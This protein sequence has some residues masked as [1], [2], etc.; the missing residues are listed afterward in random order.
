MRRHLLEV[1]EVAERIRRGETLLLAG[2]ESALRQLPRGKWIAGTIPYFMTTE[3]GMVDR[4][5]IFVEKLP[6]GFE[7]AGIR[8]YDEDGIA[9]VYVDLPPDGLGVLIAPNGS[10]V[11][12]SFAVNAPRYDR[13]A[14]RPLYGWI[15]GVHL[16][17]LGKAV[18][19]VLDGTTG[20]ALAQHAVVMHV[21]VPPGKVVELGIL[22]PF[23][24]GSGPA[25]TFPST[26]F[27][28][29][30]AEIDG[31]RLE[32]AE[33]IRETRLDTCLPLVADYYG[34]RINVSFQRVGDREV[35]FYAPVFA[36]V[37]YHHARPVADYV[38]AFASA[39]PT[40]LGERIALSCTCVLNYVHSSLE[41]RSTGDIVG[42]VTFGEIAYQLLNQ[43]MVYVTI[44]DAASPR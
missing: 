26:G 28:A 5:R 34:A 21:S 30:T 32:L 14:T 25:I 33:Y 19:R 1:D 41:G 3:G 29:T 43:T 24:K 39:L 17:D 2:D 35:W 44:S 31:R 16:S 22:N 15:S 37:R 36:G 23:E 42:P 40:G 12:L 4:R 7:C 13:F 11:H 8:R 9:R 10:R 27:S 18:P 20:E 38:D 6:E